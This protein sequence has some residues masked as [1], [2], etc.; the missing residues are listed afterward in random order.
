[1]YEGQDMILRVAREDSV[2]LYQLLEAYE[3]LA[4]YSTLTVDKGLGYRD[5]GIYPAPDLVEELELVLRGM[6]KEISFQ[7]IEE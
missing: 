1:M 7:R 6:A 5:I 2:F 4:N 3:G